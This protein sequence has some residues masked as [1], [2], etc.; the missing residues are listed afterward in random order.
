MPVQSMIP[1]KHIAQMIM[2]IV[3]MKPCIPPELSR[4]DSFEIIS[5]A[6]SGTLPIDTPLLSM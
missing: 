5:E 2:D 4:S 1:P 6:S 3:H